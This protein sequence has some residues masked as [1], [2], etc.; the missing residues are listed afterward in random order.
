VA[1][2]LDRTRAVRGVIVTAASR[3]ACGTIEGPDAR[4][5]TA[6]GVAVADPDKRAGWEPRQSRRYRS[7]SDYR[8]ERRTAAH[9]EWA[10][11]AL[12]AW[13]PAPVGDRHYDGAS[14]EVAGA[15][16]ASNRSARYSGCKIARWRWNDGLTKE[17]LIA[18]AARSTLDELADWTV[19]ADRVLTF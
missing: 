4:N 11:A 14:T 19:E 10:R 8:P 3:S 16:G 2:A 9:P 6:E 13:T 18:E 1:G 7:Q 5:P 17:Q 15:S 12:L